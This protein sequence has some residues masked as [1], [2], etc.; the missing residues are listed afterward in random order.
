MSIIVDSRDA[1]SHPEIITYLRRTNCGVATEMLDFA[2]YYFTAPPLPVQYD[3]PDSPD[4]VRIN[5]NPMVTVGIELSSVSDVCG[6]INSGRLGF[7]L[8]GMIERYRI[9]ILLIYPYPTVISVR[10][11]RG[12]PERWIKTG[13]PLSVRYTR[14]ESML[15]AAQMHGVRVLYSP[16]RDTIPETIHSLYEYWQR[17]YDEHKSYRPVQLE[18]EARIPLGEAVDAS[19][20]TLM[21]FPKV[22]EDKALA[23]LK[24]FGSLENVLAMPEAALKMVP[25]VGPTVARNIRTQLENK[26]FEGTLV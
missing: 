7:Q 17:P 20:S 13:G 2:D 4:V 18:Y 6:K 11:K 3:E 14:W 25:G 19:V 15:Y 22:G 24:A 23:L 1:A 16:E 8:S 5:T 26:V 21:T 12:D 10:D 9:P